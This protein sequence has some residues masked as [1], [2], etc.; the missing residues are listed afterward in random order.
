M[1]APRLAGASGPSATFEATDEAVDGL[2][3]A[4]LQ[5]QSR[6]SPMSAFDPKRTSLVVWRR[7]I[8]VKRV[9]RVVASN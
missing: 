1:D 6:S 9:S 4:L 5:L 3:N 8:K 7:L 2:S